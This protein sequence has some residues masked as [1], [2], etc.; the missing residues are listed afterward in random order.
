MDKICKID[1]IFEIIKT[2]DHLEWGDFFLFKEYPTDWKNPRGEFVPIYPYVIAQ[3]DITLR[4]VDDQYMYI[5]TQS[6]K[7]VD[8]VKSHYEIESVKLDLLENLDFPD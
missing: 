2:I 4:A 8:I 1:T 7:F 6:E 5:Y 3:A